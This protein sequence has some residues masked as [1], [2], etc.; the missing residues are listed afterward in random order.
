M[1][2]F[3]NDSTSK[4][5]TRGGHCKR[6]WWVY[7][8]VLVVIIVIVVPCILL[9]AVPRIAQSKINAATLNVDSIIISQSE[10]NSLN[11]AINS[12]ISTDGKTHATI[13]A[14][15]ATYYLLDY[16]P[17][18]EFATIEFPEVSA[19]SLVVVNVSQHMPIEHMTELTIFNTYLL[20]KETVR[21][22]IK[23]ETT[24]R[25]SGIA[26]DYPV[27]FDKDIEMVGFN[28]FNGLSIENPQVRLADTNNFNG[29]VHLPNPTIWTIEVGNATLYTFFN[30]SI[31]GNTY[32]DDLVLRPGDNA[33]FITGDIDQGAVLNGL[34]QKPYCENG[35][36]LPFQ[37]TGN[38]VINNGQPLP[39]F[40]DPLADK[41]DTVSIGIGAA[42]KSSFGLSVACAGS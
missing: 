39:W 4:S 40:A 8:L 31:V 37:I 35:G 10:T 33:Y 25:V 32:I 12:T 15:N 1:S 26:R 22:K 27:T 23:G 30:G 9:V 6:F 13:A 17:V 14:F 42:V 11:M 16:D 2:D 38:T 3:T 20:E 29:T 24:V 7:L 36:I 34:A 28:S 41:N 5:K 19:E 18:F 21:I